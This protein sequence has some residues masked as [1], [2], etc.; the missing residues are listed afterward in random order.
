LYSSGITGIVRF[1]RVTEVFLSDFLY[2]IQLIFTNLDEDICTCYRGFLIWLFISTSINF[3]EFGWRLFFFILK[4]VRCLE[5]S[6]Y[7]KLQK[8]T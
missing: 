1:V 6:Q 3:H 4:G 2:R 7:I 5:T 8:Q